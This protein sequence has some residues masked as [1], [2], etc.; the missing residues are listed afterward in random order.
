LTEKGKILRS[1]SVIAVFTVLSRICGYLRDQRIA[2]LLGTSPIADS[3]IL[4][5]RIPNMVRRFTGEGALGASFIPV[6]TAY[7]RGESKADTWRFAQRAF[8]DLAVVLAALT[9]LCTIFSKQVVAAFTFFAGASAGHWDMAVQLNRIIFP[10]ILFLGLSGLAFAILNSFHKF[11]LP[12]ASSVIFNLVVIASSFGIIYRPVLQHLP[13]QW[14]TPAIVLAGGI[15]VASVVQLV[16][17]LPALKRQGMRFAPDINFSD[18]GVRK[19]GKLLAPVLVATGVF[20]LNFFIDT[21]FATSSRMPSGSITSLYVGD[22][23]ME[24]TLGVYAIALSTA[25]L[26]TMSHMAADG[27]FAEMKQTFGFALRV[28]SFI[29]IPAT[30]GLI[31]FRTP[32]TRV[33]FEHGAFTATSTALTANALLYYALGL[34]AFAAIKLILP[35]F[36]A[37]HDTATPTRIGIYIVLFHIALNTILLFGFSKYLWN[38]GPALASSTSAYLNFAGLFLIFRRRFGSLQTHAVAK[39]IAKMVACAAAMALACIAALR[40]FPFEVSAGVATQA[41]RLTLMILVATAI[42]FAAAHLLKC[43]ELPEMRMLASRTPDA[44]AATDLDG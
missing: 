10:C 29:T 43:E 20:Q 6:F 42:Y 24:L 11:A 38:A 31:L 22:R 41:A 2:L 25:I 3:F 27:R 32:I 14:Q 33:L 21:I 19:T 28:V 7:L 36:Y 18:P 16:M 1:A 5:F 4:A 34:P 35:M 23:V 9:L 15:L 37:T 12:A 44:A 30:V 39:A 17:Q 40:H 8:W 13:A 26:P